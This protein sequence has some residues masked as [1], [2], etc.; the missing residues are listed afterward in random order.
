MHSKPRTTLHKFNAHAMFDK[1]KTQEFMDAK[2]S[3]EDYSFIRKEARDIDG[4][5]LELKRQKAA[6]DYAQERLDL[7]KEKASEKAEKA[8]QKKARLLEVELIFDKDEIES[9]K[10]DRLKDQFAAYALVDAPFPKDKEAFRLV[11][12][13][14]D[15]YNNGTWKP[16]IQPT[17][18]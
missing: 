11:P 17:P 2:S 13:K 14:R 9:L 12:G 3:E 18:D 6:I 15:A 5:K 1:N 7:K 10:G 16:T 8:A 4:S